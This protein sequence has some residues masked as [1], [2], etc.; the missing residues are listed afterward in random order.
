MTG[1]TD[2]SHD[3]WGATAA[4][5]AA[6]V[7]RDRLGVRA[8]VAAIVLG[9]G[10]GDVVGRLHNAQSLPYDEIPGFSA[11]S[12]D[13]HAGRLYVGTLGGREVVALAGRFHMYEGHTARAAAF[14]VR[15]VHA[16]GARV[17][18]ASNAAGGLDRALKPGDLVLLDDHI[19][20]TGQNPLTGAA[21]PG[22]LRFPDMSAAHSPRL[23]A[24]VRAAAA[25]LG[26]PLTAGVY[27]G[28]MGPVYETPTEVRM[29]AQLGATVT[30]MSTVCEAIVAA[31]LGMEFVAISLVANAA[32]GLSDAPIR[33]ADVMVAAGLV[34]KPFG[35]LLERFVQKL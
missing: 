19:N 3:P 21:E 28:L 22:D 14:P 8:P 25:E 17:L 15:V 9:S 23:R 11:T 10:L 30:G 29:L 2:A 34:S 26:T 24:L 5:A 20:L 6:A 7:A 12:V 31:A 33:H 35:D 1:A 4:R 27:V 16:L 32:A 18:F 13:G